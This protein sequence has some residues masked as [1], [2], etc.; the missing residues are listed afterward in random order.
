MKKQ[1]IEFKEIDGE[2]WFKFNSEYEKLK[3]KYGNIIMI[4]TLI[5]C[6]GLMIMFFIYILPNINL[7]KTSPCV[8]CESG[9]WNCMKLFPDA[10][11]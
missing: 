7:L 2:T 5:L 10:F 1:K 11:K 9:G 8:L 3:W 4:I 6:F